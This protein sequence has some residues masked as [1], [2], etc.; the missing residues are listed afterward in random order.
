MEKKVMVSVVIPTLNRASSIGNLVRNLMSDPYPSK[1]IIVVDGGSKDD[2]KNIAREV[3][4]VVIDEKGEEQ[5]PANAR[6]Q[7]VGASKGE[8]INF[9]DGD[10]NV[11]P[12]FISNVIRHFSDPNVVAAISKL[13]DQE[14][15]LIQRICKSTRKSS[16]TSF[17]TKRLLGKV[18]PFNFMRK[19]L[20]NEL[21]GWPK[22]GVHDDTILANRLHVYLKEHPEKKV[23]YEP[24]SVLRK[25]L[26]S[27]AKELFKESVF[28]GRTLILYLNRSKLPLLNKL[29]QLAVPSCYPILIL[30]I[31]LLLIS[32]WFLVLTIPYCVRTSFIFFEAIKTRNKYRLLTP[33]ID[34]IIGAGY[35]VGLSRFATR[36]HPRAP[37]L[38]PWH[39]LRS[40]TNF[41]RKLEGKLAGALECLAIV[42][43]VIFVFPLACLEHRLSK[44]KKARPSRDGRL[45]G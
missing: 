39:P 22:I 38:T 10:N 11:D 6:N 13:E 21:G 29:V 17:F 40:V 25:W 45:E 35:L 41:L 24:N 8:V 5:S 34:F 9:M 12:L 26:P 32:P 33:I 28:Y 14:N 43:G 7:G 19:D 23:V 1:E 31:P 36:R 2:T 15:T 3:G 37:I 16:F 20:F 42:V 44:R 18:C 4:A 27:S 30:S